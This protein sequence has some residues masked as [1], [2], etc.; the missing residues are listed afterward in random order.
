MSINEHY[1]IKDKFVGYERLVKIFRDLADRREL[2]HDY[3]FFGEQ[4]VGKFTFASRL[5]GYL[6]F[7]S[8]EPS[9]RASSESMLVNPSSEESIGIDQVRDIKYFLSKQPAASFYRTVIIDNAEV[10]T[11]QAQNALLKISEEPPPH[12]L[13]ILIVANPESLLPTLRSRFQKVY[14]PR[15]RTAEIEQHLRSDYGVEAKTAKDAAEHSFGR[16][17]R[18]IGLASGEEGLRSAR[19][20]ALETLKS[21]GGAAFRGALDEPK[22]LE[23]LI[24]EMIAELHKNPERNFA[25]L[26]ELLKR[27]ALN[28]SLNTNKRLQLETALWTI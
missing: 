24:R 11:D 5:A 15:L 18:A 7:G 14:F 28:S 19:K 23:A 26:K 12:G 22:K 17:G 10:L 6:E 21:R 20:N 16:M 3:I 4:G 2:S 8:F 27:L 13:I 1:S 9:K 25:G